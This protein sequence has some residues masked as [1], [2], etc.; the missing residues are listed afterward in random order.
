FADNRGGGKKSGD[1]RE[2]RHGDASSSGGRDRLLSFPHNCLPE[3]LLV[4]HTAGIAL[5][6]ALRHPS[7]SSP[8]LPSSKLPQEELNPSIDLLRKTAEAVGDFRKTPIYIVGTIQ[9]YALASVLEP[10]TAA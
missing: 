3:A 10:N 9:R 6:R 2:R 4:R 8:R 1:G 7:S 5:R